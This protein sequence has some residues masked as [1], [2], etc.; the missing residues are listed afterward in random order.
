MRSAGRLVDRREVAW[1]L[2]SRKFL[3]VPAI[4]DLFGVD[5]STLYRR[6]QKVTASQAGMARAFMDRFGVAISQQWVS[7]ILQEHGVTRKRLRVTSSEAAAQP[8]RHLAFHEAVAGADETDLAS[9]DESSF[10][11][12]EGPSYLLG[13]VKGAAARQLWAQG[14]GRPPMSEDGSEGR[15]PLAAPCQGGG[16]KVFEAE[17]IEPGW[18]QSLF[19]TSGVKS[20]VERRS[21][22]NAPRAGTMW[23]RECG[24]KAP[25][26]WET[27][28]ECPRGDAAAPRRGFEPAAPRPCQSFTDVCTAMEIG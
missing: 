16:R 20:E 6:I 1:Q 15:A 4:C 8:E 28:S 24:E 26:C 27:P 5:R 3:D 13:D 14:R 12:N 23:Y 25:M 22:D 17:Q 10:H 19:R 11:I 18:Q 21:R 7:K 9:L 2:K